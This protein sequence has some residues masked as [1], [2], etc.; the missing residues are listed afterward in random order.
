MEQSKTFYAKIFGDRALITMPET[1]SGGEKY[2]YQVP[3]REMLRGILDSNYFKPTFQNVV[4]EIRIM[5]PIETES[6]GI[7]LLKSD[8]KP[9]LSSYTYLADV[10][11]YV[12]YHLEWNMEREDL[13]KDR[14][15]R[16]H[17]E[18]TER[19][20]K[21]GGRRPIFLGVSECMGYI[22]EL[23]AS[24]YE[25]DPGYYDNTNIGFGIM[26]VGFLYP[27]KSG[28]LLRAAYAPIHMQHGRI[29]YPRPEDCPMINEVGN[30]TF[31]EPVLTKTAEEELADD[32]GGLKV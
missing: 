21:R 27:K 22:E 30:Y 4:E 2:S 18:I 32:V 23:T 20:L 7:R 6:Q 17:E 31:R 28:E 26:F 24:D 3:T 29:V 11:Y 1:K 9:D 12:K 13:A 14:N 15:M 25:Q 8:Y 10:C 5:K 16:K 19:S